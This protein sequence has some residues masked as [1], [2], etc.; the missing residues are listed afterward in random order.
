MSLPNL[1]NTSR[2]QLPPG[3]I[4]LGWPDGRMAKQ[5]RSPLRPCKILGEHKISVYSLEKEKY[6]LQAHKGDVHPLTE[7]T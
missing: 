1:E 6:H 5:A 4:V 2:F 3:T 7:E